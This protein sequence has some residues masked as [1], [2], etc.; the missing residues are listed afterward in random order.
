MENGIIP[1]YRIQSFELSNVDTMIG[2]DFS[3][4]RDDH[5]VQSLESLDL[6]R[7]ALELVVQGEDL[8]PSEIRE[9]TTQ[10]LELLRSKGCVP[11]DAFCLWRLMETKTL[12]REWA[13]LTESENMDSATI[14]FDGTILKSKSGGQLAVLQPFANRGHWVCGWTPLFAA[15]DQPENSTRSIC[16]YTAVIRAD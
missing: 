10:N 6:S 9:L 16:E 15:F 13:V 14:R 12:P 2:H 7:L 1:L 11:L 8:R 4:V 5:A 3:I